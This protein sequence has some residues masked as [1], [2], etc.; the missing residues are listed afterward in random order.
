MKRPRTAP[1]I[2]LGA[3]LLPLCAASADVRAW[4]ADLSSAEVRVERLRRGDVATLE[5][6]LYLRGAP[7]APT[8]ATCHYRSSLASTNW[9]PAACAVSSN[10]V[11]TVVSPLL[12]IAGDVVPFLF[13]IDGETYRAA[14][15]VYLSDSPG[16]A[17][18]VGPPVLDF[19]AYAITNAPWALPSDIPA[20][21]VTSVNGQT[22][23]VALAASDIGAAT[24]ADATLTART[25][26]SDWVF[27]EGLL[28]AAQECFGPNIPALA[29]DSHLELFADVGG[30]ETVWLVQD[31]GP[32]RVDFAGASLRPG[33][34]VADLVGGMP[35]V[36]DIVPPGGAIATRA[37]LTGYQLG[38]QSDKPLAAATHTH[39]ADEVSGLPDAPDYSATNAALVATIQAVAPP[40]GDYETVSNLATSAV[41]PSELPGLVPEYIVSPETARGTA[42]TGVS[43]DTALRDGK[44]ILLYMAAQPSA[45][46]TLNLTLADGSTTGAKPVRF[47]GTTT[48]TT[49]YAAGSILPLVYRAGAW[50]VSDRDT[51]NDTYD[52]VRV[53]TYVRFSAQTTKYAICCGTTNGYRKV[54]PGVAFDASMPILY[55]NVNAT[56]A[57]GAQNNNFYSAMPNVDVR[58]TVSG[59]ASRRGKPLYLVGTLAADG[60]TFTVGDPAL[61]YEPTPPCIPLGIFNNNADNQLYFLPGSLIAGQT[62]GDA[63]AVTNL[64]SDIL[65]EEVDALP[66]QSTLEVH[67]LVLADLW[68]RVDRMSG[69]SDADEIDDLRLAISGLDARLTALEESTAATA[70]SIS[71]LSAMSS[72]RLQSSDL[73]A[74]GSVD[75]QALQDSALVP[76]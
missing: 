3:L 44:L 12:E 19:G 33:G 48:V 64:V 53:N 55:A 69:S 43:R 66:V 63:S 30:A 61:S 40:P 52:R 65:A 26:F 73:Q 4:R 36:F 38:S 71:A 70:A 15:M 2:L 59:F 8:N 31:D 25:G 14:A 10:T 72:F 1:A 29:T 18:S 41:Q 7:Y 32:A 11:S 68:D 49:H 21:P 17:P 23:A 46:W 62:G 34:L 51:N 50:Y 74:P 54:A 13:R 20:P 39:T 24:V 28:E 47:W 9:L 22:G 6:R 60:R 16:D 75:A 27:A 5:A 35:W 67:R 37:A 57:A 56:S 58:N 42:Y 45:A 76:D